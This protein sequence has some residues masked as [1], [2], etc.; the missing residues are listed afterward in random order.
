MKAEIP[1]I[2]RREHDSSS[3][4]KK[5]NLYYWNTDTLA[6]EKVGGTSSGIKI[7]F[8]SVNLNDLNDVNAGSPTDGQALT[9]DNATSKWIASTIA[10]GGTWGSIT[11]TLSDQTDLQT[12]LDA[13]LANV[14]EDTTPQLGGDLDTQGYK[15]K[16]TDSADKISFES[17][18]TG[19][20]TPPS[21]TTQSVPSTADAGVVSYWKMDDNGVQ[22]D[23]ANDANCLLAYKF[24]EGSGTTLDDATNNNNDAAITGA[25]WSSETPFASGN[26]L[27]FDTSTDYARVDTV[28]I[29][30]TQQSGAL[31]FWFK[32]ATATTGTTIATY[33]SSGSD[34]ELM[35]FGYALGGSWAPA[36]NSR[37]YLRS[38]KANNDANDNQILGSTSLSDNTWYHVVFASTGSGYRIYLNGVEETLTVYRGSN[39]GDWFAD[40]SGAINHYMHLGRGVRQSGQIGSAYGHIAYFSMLDAVPSADEIMRRYRQS[41]STFIA[42]Y[43]GNNHGAISGSGFTTGL[44]GYTGDYAL[45]LESSLDTDYVTVYLNTTLPAELQ[46]LSDAISF[47]AWITPESVTGTAPSD[48]IQNYTI[49]ELRRNTT[50]GAHVPFSFGIT[51][52]KLSLGVADNYIT[53]AQKVYSTTTLVAGTQYHVAFTIDG[54]NWVLYING[55]ADASGTFTATGDRSVGS[56][57]SSLMLGVRTSDGGVVDP[58]FDFDGI[59][60]NAILYNDVRTATEMKNDYINGLKG[61]GQ[62][63]HLKL[64]DGSGTTAT[65]SSAEG[66]NGTITDATWTGSGAFGYTGD[67]GLT[68]NG[69]SAKVEIADDD[70]LDF[71]GSYTAIIWVK[72]STN[73]STNAIFFSKYDDGITPGWLLRFDANDKINYSHKPSSGS[74]NNIISSSS[75]NDG[76][77]HMVAARFTEGTGSELFV[78][79]VSVGTATTTTVSC[80]ASTMKVV[81]GAQDYAPFPRYY[82]GQLDQAMLY[83]YA[84]TDDEILAIYNAGLAVGN[85]FYFNTTNAFASASELMKFANNDTDKFIIYGDGGIEMALQTESLRIKDAGSTGATEQD[86]V[87]VETGGN[88]GYLRVFST[89]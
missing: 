89:K 59:I 8:S 68:F 57:A 17:A 88:T 44:F 36:G 60:D 65:D 75:Y 32:T 76:N 11:G 85:A 62:V 25:V 70:T 28:N 50:T 52:S 34:V 14:V 64:D 27:H 49:I 63:L 47:Q 58:N 9:W 79:G 83:N 2:I 31:E 53:G 71:T 38:Y 51:N 73:F 19:E 7:D 18:V 78:D 87:E 16:T 6:W 41:Q 40:L 43:V 3:G 84:L 45:N 81:L 61:G 35:M 82:T 33:S 56:G 29:G 48:W 77:W 26:S 10:S 22:P 80:G 12:A 74:A 4:H 46:T 21:T 54:D 69:T 66:N 23:V 24:T 5:A 15:I 37:L 1:E 55:V 13:K 39:D 42:D 20:G 86:W 67:N 30:K 72:T